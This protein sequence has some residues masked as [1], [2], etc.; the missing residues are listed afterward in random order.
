M[1][2][3]LRQDSAGREVS[4]AAR[5]AYAE[6]L[7]L[8]ILAYR[9]QQAAD[10]RLMATEVAA[11]NED[12]ASESSELASSNRRESGTTARKGPI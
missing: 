5:L 4:E 11:S 10:D 6:Q 8:E 7:R 3:A 9:E 2:K 12:A 1:K